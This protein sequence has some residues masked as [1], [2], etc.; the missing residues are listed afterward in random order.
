MIFQNSNFLRIFTQKWK[1]EAV[2]HI[3]KKYQVFTYSPVHQDFREA[4]HFDLVQIDPNLKMI[5]ENPKKYFY[6]AEYRR[7]V[8]KFDISRT[9]DRIAYEYG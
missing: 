4:I 1:F 7:M 8:F 3:G 9:T 6:N 2:H 5:K